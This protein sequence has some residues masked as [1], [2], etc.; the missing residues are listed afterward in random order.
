M[1]GKWFMSKNNVR[2][3]STMSLPDYKD[4]DINKEWIFQEWSRKWN[5]N[6]KG[7]K[8]KYFFWLMEYDYNETCQKEAKNKA[9]NF[10]IKKI[11]VAGYILISIVFFMYLINI[12]EIL[13]GW[14]ELPIPDVNWTNIGVMFMAYFIWGTTL[15][16]IMKWTEVKKFQETWK[17]H[18]NH[19]FQVEME[20]F[21][22]ITQYGEYNGVDA[23]EKFI[24]KLMKI[25]EGN[26]KKF[27]NNMDKE[28]DINDFN[29]KADEAIGVLSSLIKR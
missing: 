12:K 4:H 20:M 16:G 21:K 23:N 14:I 1:E 25:W 27:S 10:R 6:N 15:A 7:E 24:E 3:D 22:Y 17:R 9:W 13:S 2:K 19:R 11:C 26:Q 29:K 8:D 5:N 18:S 28:K